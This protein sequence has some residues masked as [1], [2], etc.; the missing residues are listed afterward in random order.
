MAKTFF[1]DQNELG[2]VRRMAAATATAAG[3]AGW[4]TVN[5]GDNS[6]IHTYMRE[7]SGLG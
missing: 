6:N 2:D 4:G 5:I 1:C 3:R 7:L